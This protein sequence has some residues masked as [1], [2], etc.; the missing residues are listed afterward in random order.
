[1]KRD[2][3][4]NAFLLAACLICFSGAFQLAAAL[5]SLTL[6]AVTGVKG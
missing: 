4:R 5:S 1:M 6:V 2:V 3:R